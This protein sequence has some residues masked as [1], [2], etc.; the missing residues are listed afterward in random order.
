MPGIDSAVRTITDS[1]QLTAT[2]LSASATYTGTTRDGG[3]DPEAWPTRIRPLV[4]HLTSA[5]T[6]HGHLVLDESLDGTTWLETKRSPIPAD[7]EHRT[8][9]WPLHLRYHRLRFINGSQAQTGMRLAYTTYRGEGGS[10]DEREVLGFLL[11]ATALAASATFT[12]PTIDLGANA[13]RGAVRALALA[14]QAGTSF[15]IEW[16]DD[17]TTWIAAAD[18][19]AVP[20]AAT[21]VGIEARVIARYARVVFVNGATAQGSFRL[22]ATVISL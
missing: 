22:L 11:S 2:N 10:V 7:G 13:A 14:G 8:F 16:S 5:K 19:Q 15:R 4:R 20:A 12:S 9:D 3:A 17:G 6:V 1:A 18:A 21:P